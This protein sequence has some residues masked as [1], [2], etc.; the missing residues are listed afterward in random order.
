MPKSPD[1]PRSHRR[2]ESSPLPLAQALEHYLTALTLEGKSPETRRWY[3]QRLSAFVAFMDQPGTPATLADFTLERGRDFVRSLMER[4]TTYENHVYRRQKAQGLSPHT[5]HSFVRAI[6]AF[7]AW[8]AEEAYLA[9]NVLQPMRPPK[10]PKLIIQPLSEIELQLLLKSV[11]EYSPEKER[12]HAMLLVFLDCGLRVSELVGLRA[13]DIDFAVGELKVLGKGSKERTVPVGLTT[14][15]AMLRY[16]DQFRPEPALPSEDH[17]F[18]TGDGRPMT[19]NGVEHVIAALAKRSGV[20][21]L[22]PHLLRHTAAVSYIKNGGDA[23]SLQ[24]I[25]GHESLDVT[26]RY[27]DLA[28]SDVLEKHRRFS[29]VDNL[30]Q[31]TRQPGRPRSQRRSQ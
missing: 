11:N 20:S 1:R 23:F 18:L 15:R 7:S 3:R 31:N 25:L 24:R 9:E 30:T 27:V 16:Q 19:R 4:Q 12:N 17:F 21:R 8:L 2:S 13:P 22:H 5:I 28:N 6:R 29:P 26:R 10:L 14:R